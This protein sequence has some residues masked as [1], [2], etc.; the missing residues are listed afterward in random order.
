M[1]PSAP[2]LHLS[3]HWLTTKKADTHPSSN[4][5]DFI[6]DIVTSVAILK[7]KTLRVLWNCR[8][9]L[10]LLN[11]ILPL[12]EH[13]RTWYGRL[14]HAAQLNQS[15]TGSYMPLKTSIYYAHLLHMGATM[16]IFRRCLAMLRHPR[17]RDDLSEEHQESLE[18]TL[19]DGINAAQHTAR[20]LFLVREASQSVR[21]CWITM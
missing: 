5:Q 14:P 16:L 2:T 8:S 18:A 17:D 10:D 11:S 3:L 1:R 6:Q 20:I 4:E 9:A 19:H 21:H 7:A 15:S 12:E 13:L